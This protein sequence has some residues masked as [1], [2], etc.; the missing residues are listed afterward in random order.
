MASESLY[1]PRPSAAERTRTVSLSGTWDRVGLGAIVILAAVLN[2]YGLN[3]EGYGNT[4]YASAVKSMSE[5]WHNFFFN[6]F[7]PGGF[8]TIDKP[9]VGFWLQVLSTKIFGF[10]GVALMLPQALAGVLSVAVLFY[11][12]R[13]TFGPAA[14]LLAGLALALT[15]ITVVASRNN[16]IDGTLVLA[17]L[18]GA[19]AVLR[20][21][22][23]GSLRWLLVC[24]LCVG[25]GFN[26]KMLEAFLV[27]PAFGLVYLL[28]A[29][30]SW[31]RRI[32]HLVVAGI[33]LLVV[34]FSWV[35]AVD[36]TPAG[37][38]PWV[39][40][41][42]NNSELTLAIGYNGLQR[43]TG[44]AAPGGGGGA[45][46]TSGETGAE[47][48]LRLLNTQL[49]SQIGWLLPLAIIG[50]IGAAVAWRRQWPLD[51]YARSLLLWGTWLLTMGVFFSVAGF[52]HVYY[53]VMMAPGIAALCGIGVV[54][55]WR[56]YRT[57]RW[58]WWLLPVSLLVVAMVQAH[59]L[60]DY[61]DWSRWLSPLAIG[62]CA[63][64]GIGLVLA[65]YRPHPDLRWGVVAVLLGTT[66]LLA[67][68]AAWAADS[69]SNADSGA[70]PHAGPAA[71]VGSGG[72]RFGFA[73]GAFN[74]SPSERAAFRRGNFSR[75]SFTPP[76]GGGFTPRSGGFGRGGLTPPTGGF[77]REG[78]TPPAG[79]FGR[80]GFT[81]GGFPGG[82]GRGF[83]GGNT[84]NTSL[85][86]YLEKHQGTTKFLMATTNIGTAESYILSTGKPV[87]AMG[88]FLGSDPIL[89][90]TRV[91]ALVKDNV[92]RYFL[93]PGINGFGAGSLNAPPTQTRAGTQEFGF[94]SRA[95]LPA[96]G[97]AREFGAFGGGRFGASN[98][99]TTWV[100]NHCS[101][102]P[103]AQYESISGTGQQ[104][105]SC[106]NGA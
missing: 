106:G 69:V 20:A 76:S 15:P 98:A 25:I 81:P 101:V 54:A 92:I 45:A 58:V 49:G 22:E 72:G 18:L 61:P 47:G 65:R 17:V 11:L 96:Q 30:T 91:A 28:G 24:A 44:R 86:R 89:N 74:L 99:V 12:V 26:I 57:S 73:R 71:S 88:G 50:F 87:M 35:M 80:G 48:P 4:Y 32:V 10:N 102:V 40:S 60:T 59:L 63:L 68:P 19:W 94:G 79:G 64:A 56:L 14:G 6:S 21:A 27:L 43:L 84:V 66:G 75:G 41:T 42:T 1:P 3:R 13:R 52:F 104:L 55:L 67:A 78:F 53:M 70:L 95:A 93:L 62:L 5:N 8:V 90:P 7:D 16:I 36:A 29:C 37:S 82:G 39:D 33:A 51:G 77:G 100:Q 38:R 103:P 2:F 9:P 83:G 34:S 85:L 46:F 31:R 105:Y 97:R 23:T